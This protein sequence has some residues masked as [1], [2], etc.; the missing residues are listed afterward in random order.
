MFLSDRPGDAPRQV[1]IPPDEPS[2]PGNGLELAD[3]S[4]DG[5]YLAFTF[6]KWAYFSDWFHH[7]LVIYDAQ[8]S[9]AS[10]LDVEAFFSRQ[11]GKQ[12]AIELHALGFDADGHPV[13]E[14]WGNSEDDLCLAEKSPWRVDLRQN[15]VSPLPKGFKSS[16]IGKIIE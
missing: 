5:R 9:Q 14:A 15:S 2:E 1:L 12:C 13:V 11:F 3:W 16:R 6:H 4:S 10:F 7:D 8:S